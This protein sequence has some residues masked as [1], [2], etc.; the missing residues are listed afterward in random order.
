[1]FLSSHTAWVWVYEQNLCWWHEIILSW[2]SVKISPLAFFC[3]RRRHYCWEFGF[4]T[5]AETFV[6][7][8]HSTGTSMTFVEC[9][10]IYI[11]ETHAHKVHIS[12]Y[13]II[14]NTWNF[15]NMCVCFFC[16][17]HLSCSLKHPRCHSNLCLQN[18]PTSHYDWLYSVCSIWKNM[19]PLAT[20]KACASA[21]ILNPQR[22][23]LISI[24]TEM[25]INLS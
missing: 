23:V 6:K 25:H 15:E 24:H 22:L 12:L 1:M 19:N 20:E 9:L 16:V 7:R 17:V 18:R 4:S 3:G 21:Y 2:C 8:H 13:L 5:S 10:Y 11:C 14:C